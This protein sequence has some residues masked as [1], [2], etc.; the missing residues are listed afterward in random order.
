[1]PSG[2]TH[3]HMELLLL[4]GFLIAFH[5][6][7]DPRW[8]ELLLFASAFLAGSLWL[9]PDLDLRANAAR[10]RWGPLG[11]IWLPYAKAFR[12]R[13]ISH[14]PLVG[15]L[16]R[17]LYLGLVLGAVVAALGSLGFTLPRTSQLPA[18]PDRWPWIR[19]LIASG[20]GLYLPN[21]LHVLLDRAASARTRR[22]RRAGR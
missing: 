10:R 9:S 19:A 21:V 1:M 13:G 17:L 18:G 7:L 6:L 14:S 20:A 15:P 12:H 16:T 8:T 22:A 2:K 11:F 3:V 4:P 5:A